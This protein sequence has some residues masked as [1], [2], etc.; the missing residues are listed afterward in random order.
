MGTLMGSQRPG[1]LIVKLNLLQYK[2]NESLSALIKIC[3]L[4]FYENVE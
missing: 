4:K 2:L 3:D 1:G